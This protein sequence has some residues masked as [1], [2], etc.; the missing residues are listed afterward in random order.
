MK[1]KRHISF[2]LAAL[3]I[4]Q[5]FAGCGKEKS[6]DENSP[7]GVPADAAAAGTGGGRLTGTAIPLPDGGIYRLCASDD[8]QVYC[9][10]GDGNGGTGFYQ[11]N[12]SDNT[13][14]PMAYTTSRSLSTMGISPE[15]NIVSLEYEDDGDGNFIYTL[16]EA[17]SNGQVLSS[18]DLTPVTEQDGT[19][20]TGIMPVEGGT[21]VSMFN[22]VFLV[23]DQGAVEHKFETY[24]ANRTIVKGAE[25][26][27]LLCGN[28]PEGYI[29]DELAPDLKI[30]TAYVLENNY[31]SAF[32]GRNSGGVYLND[33]V[34]IYSVDYKSGQR[35][36]AVDILKSGMNASSF[37]CVGENT[38]LTLERDGAMLWTPASGD[39]GETVTLKMAANGLD[40]DLYAV[41]SEFNKSGSK[42]VIEVEDYSTYATGADADAGLTRLNTEIIS[43][44]VPDIFDLSTLPAQIYKSKGLLEDLKPFIENDDELD[45][46]SLV[47]SAV[48]ALSDNGRLYSLVPAFYVVTAFI[49]PDYVKSREEWTTVK[50]LETAKNASDKQMLSA[51]DTRDEFIKYLL[52]FSA[53][54]FAT[55]ENGAYNFNNSDFIELLKFA[56]ILPEEPDYTHYPPTDLY[57]GK[58]LMSLGP[59]GDIVSELIIGDTLFG[60][61][62][63]VSGFPSSKGGRQALSPY[64]SLGMASTSENKE[65]VWEFF[66]FLL[67]DE[68]QRELGD[69]YRCVPLRNDILKECIADSIQNTPEKFKAIAILREDGPEETA[70]CQ[71]PSPDMESRAWDI[72]NNIDCVAEYNEFIY[73]IVTDEAAAFFAGERS[74]EES[75]EIIQSRV[76]IY[77]AE[78][79]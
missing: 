58:Q 68:Y 71:P 44:N 6:P 72:I 12:I 11:L 29:V 64:M 48:E 62:C 41:I 13:V 73:S 66:S 59:V 22:N 3:M 38:F 52:V 25:G 49:S 76:S 1:I 30:K 40:G 27:I 50:F 46:D 19:V 31:N 8:G 60:K 4:L 42:Y 69:L 53:N 33:G 45:L 32:D 61:K 54:D 56:A 34:N 55:G 5:L 2:I 35:T 36:V 7:A 65:G 21:L 70:E 77:V 51:L 23:N 17:D 43:G 14:T 75:A 24:D 37:V 67:R 20:I 78:Q 15:G 79:S 9:C 28:T 16:V 63:T 26:Q 10:G 57:D 47:P 18:L 74:A 39:T